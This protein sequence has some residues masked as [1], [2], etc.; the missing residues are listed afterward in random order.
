MRYLL[1]ILFISLPALAQEVNIAKDTIK[2][3]ELVLK[4]NSKNLKLKV[5]KLRAPCYYP[6]TM[7]DASE[8]ITLV[9]NLP[10]GY[11]ETITFYFNELYYSSYQEQSAKFKDTEFELMLYTV[12]S[13]NTPGPKMAYDPK[14]I[15]VS[16]EHMGKVE[17]N[18]SNLDIKSPKKLYIGLKR[19]L[20]AATEKEFYIDCL[21]NGQDIYT[22][23]SRTNDTENW[24]P[25]SVCAALKVDVGILARKK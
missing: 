14:F 2:M 5:T 20:G 22:T 17:I 6:E 24:A 10:A 3:E 11:M 18:I 23:L 21:C 9:E 16:K 12:N 15:S 7:V 8:V 19:L 25:R 1:F 4:K 13:N